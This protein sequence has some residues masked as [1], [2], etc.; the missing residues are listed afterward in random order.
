MPVE[1]LYRKSTIG[2]AEGGRQK[3]ARRGGKKEEN[4]LL[5]PLDYP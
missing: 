5:A 2:K 3:T 1:G 4:L